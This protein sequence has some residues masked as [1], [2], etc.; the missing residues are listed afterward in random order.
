MKE[1]VEELKSDLRDLNA[2]ET[3]SIP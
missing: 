3:D 1:L 2:T